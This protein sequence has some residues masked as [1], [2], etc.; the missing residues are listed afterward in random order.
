MTDAKSD[1]AIF[2]DSAEEIQQHVAELKALADCFRQTG[3]EYMESK[4]IRIAENTGWKIERIIDIHRATNK[5]L[6]QCAEK[7][8]ELKEKRDNEHDN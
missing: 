6:Y 7:C 4:L 1:N 5:K 2:F 8:L 3:N